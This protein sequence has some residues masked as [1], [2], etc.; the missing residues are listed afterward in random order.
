M[1]EQCLYTRIYGCGVGK[2]LMTNAQI[3]MGARLQMHNALN[4]II[5][6]SPS[7]TLK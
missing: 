2:Q 6:L 3:E 1:V 4:V 5:F 7:I